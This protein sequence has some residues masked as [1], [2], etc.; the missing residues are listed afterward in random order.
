[1]NSIKREL[2][3]ANGVIALSLA[4]PGIVMTLIPQPYVAGFG[5]SMLVFGGIT[6]IRA[7]FGGLL[8]YMLAQS[9]TIRDPNRHYTEDVNSELGRKNLE[10]RRRA[11]FV[12]AGISFFFLII[13]LSLVIISHNEGGPVFSGGSAGAAASLTV[14]HI[15]SLY[16]G[17]KA[18]QRRKSAS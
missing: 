15:H 13:A 17:I 5:F 2:T 1:M 18:D 16:V 8:G 14:I 6:G 12:W 7:M 9:G 11:A 10:R 4:V 3:S